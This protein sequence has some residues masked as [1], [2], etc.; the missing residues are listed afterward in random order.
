[1]SPFTFARLAQIAPRARVF[2][3]C[4]L[5]WG[6]C[7]LRCKC[8]CVWLFVLSSALWWLSNLSRA[9]L[10]YLLKAAEIG[11]SPSATLWREKCEKMERLSGF[12]CWFLCSFTIIR[13]NVWNS[14]S[15]EGRY[16]HNEFP[17][18]EGL[19]FKMQT[20]KEKNAEALCLLVQMSKVT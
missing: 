16:Q 18:F 19:L 13:P 11:W 9:E 10:T 20:T 17:W 8:E 15:A 12:K 6:T 1:M 3:G 2:S 14:L 5:C 7:V 4:T